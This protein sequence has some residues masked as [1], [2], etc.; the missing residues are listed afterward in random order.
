MNIAKLVIMMLTTLM[1]AATAIAIP[2]PMGLEGYITDIDGL[3]QAPEGTS[4]TMTNLATG[5]VVEGSTGRGSD[6]GKF[7]VS[8]PGTEGDQVLIE[9]SSTEHNASKTV[10][11]DGFLSDILVLVNLSTTNYP[12]LILST[13]I[14]VTSLGEQYVYQVEAED[15]NNL[16]YTLIGPPSMVI[17]QTGLITWNAN[18]PGAHQVSIAVSDGELLAYQNYTLTVIIEASGPTITSTPPLTATA[19]RR[20]EYQV[21]ATDPDDDRLRYSLLISPRN[22]RIHPTKG[23]IKWRPS[24]RDIGEHDIVLQVSDGESSALQS[25]T[26]TVGDGSTGEVKMVRIPLSFEDAAIASIDYDAFGET[27]DTVEISSGATRPRSVSRLSSRTYQYISIELD[28]GE[29]ETSATVTF[30]VRKHWLE[31]NNIAPQELSLFRYVNGQWFALE[32]TF[33]H[34]LDD[35]AFYQSTTPGFSNFAIAVL[36]DIPLDEIN[37]I[38]K[39]TSNTISQT[40]ALSGNLIHKN[41]RITDKVSYEVKNARNNFTVAGETSRY[42]PSVFGIFI[43]GKIGDNITLIIKEYGAQFN[44]LLKENMINGNFIINEPTPWRF[45]LDEAALLILVVVLLLLIVVRYR[46]KKHG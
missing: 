15:E 25:Y 37:K 26:L 45:Y 42:E 9:T 35:Y 31:R 39:Y 22:M 19:Y 41:E 5:Y 33:L 44:F 3:T 17:D 30:A 43:E 29:P 18:S 38:V 16:S 27:F 36:S 14:N 10:V 46:G 32:T 23:L 24:R 20:Y 40:H 8:I 13:P 6:T 4:F 28:D 12:P 11:I 2:T 1:L 21:E 34:E 7:L